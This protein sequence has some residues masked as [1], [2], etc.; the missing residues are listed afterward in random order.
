M[1]LS[2]LLLLAGTGGG[3]GVPGESAPFRGTLG[4]PE[5]EMAL[6]RPAEARPDGGNRPP[7]GGG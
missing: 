6:Q 7:A 4:L 3:C 2:R 5:P 1:H